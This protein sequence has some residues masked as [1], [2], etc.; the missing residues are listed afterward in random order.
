MIQ[1]ASD[2]GVD[3]FVWR[4]VLSSDVPDGLADI[5]QR[6]SFAD[7]FEAHLALDAIEELRE[8]EQEKA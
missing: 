3:W 8:L 6:W 5:R 2:R 1:R 4:V 7:V